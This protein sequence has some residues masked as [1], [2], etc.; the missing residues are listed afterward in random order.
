MNKSFVQYC[1]HSAEISAFSKACFNLHLVHTK[2]K[3]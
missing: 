1:T 3:L 2:N